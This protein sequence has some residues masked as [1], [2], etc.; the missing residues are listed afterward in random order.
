[1]KEFCLLIRSYFKGITNSLKTM[2]PIKIASFV[3]VIG[4]F[5]VGSYY[6][7]LR[8]FLYLTGIEIIGIVLL[9]KTI[10]MALFV[11]FF[12]LLFSNVITSFS[13][14]YNNR[15]LSFLFSLPVRPTSI[16]LAKL[17]EN[18]VYASWAT[19]VIAFP[20]ILAYGIVTKVQFIYYP[21]SVVSILIYLIIPAAAAS[22][23]IFIILRLFPQLKSRD[24]I[25]LSL[26]FI[27]GLTFLYIKFNNPQLMK[28]FETENEQD[29]INFAANLTTVGGIYLPSTWLS[30]IL[31]G[32]S[33]NTNSGLFHFLLLLFTSAS[34]V[35]LAFFTA[36]LL[37]AR[38]WLSIGEG[39][40][41]KEMKKSLLAVYQGGQLRSFLL[42]D[43]LIF[44]REPTQWVQLSIFLI[45][46][47]VYVFSLRKTPLYFNFPLWR[48]VVS[49]GNFA[50]ISF[51]LATI[52][53]RFIFPSISLEQNGISF[54]GSAPFSFKK[55][56][57]L[58]YIVSL[59][60]AVIIIE[61]LLLLSNLLI[62]TDPQMTIIMPIIALFVAAALVSI[63]LG[64]GGRFPQ[65]SEDN[66]SKIAA[67]SG[68]IIAALA[69]IS[70]VG[71]SLLILA[72][73]AYNYLSNKYFNRQINIP[74]IILSLIFFAGFNLWIIFFSLKMG[75]NSL[76][77]RD[78]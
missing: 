67:G 35:I 34:A 70:Y 37:Y 60:L 74:L 47:G 77:Q 65:F 50:Y 64:L 49:F 39:N 66:P 4:C 55:M 19:T 25:L 15:E 38:S 11:F 32:L 58:K 62:K 41:K 72:T 21:L 13:T 52:G 57:G 71:I 45:L 22:L 36:N 51:V 76:K 73:P 29:L 42:K 14:F 24:V 10:E 30:N 28:I 75:I 6:L 2:H 68:G 20:L 8:L 33:R 78:F 23:L 54:L 69:S 56:I 59:L 26:I 43:I 53:V 18:C 17:F 5:L 16:Y 63:N 48:T 9:D 3:F 31:K 1:M 12:M 40:T 61:T 44:I 46:L 7:F 27:F